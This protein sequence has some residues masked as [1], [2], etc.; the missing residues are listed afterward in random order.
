MARGRDEL[1]RRYLEALV[2]G[3]SGRANA[4]VEQARTQGWS[5]EQIYL[6]VL[7]PAQA[8][9]GARWRARRLSVAD[10][11]LAT[12]ITLEQMDRLRERIAP[13]PVPGRHAVVA[14]VEGEGHAI[15]ARML[16]DFLLIDG[17]AVDYLGANTPTADLVELVARRDPDLVAL[18][19]TQPEHLP[20]VA[21][22]AT[23]LRRLSPPPRV[24]AGG[25]ALQ[26]RPRAAATLAVDAVAADALSGMHEA[27]RVVAGAPT[28]QATGKDYFQRLGQQVQKLRS[29]KGWTQQQL[30]AAAGLDR[31]YISGLERGKQNPTVGA[32]LRLARA[33][34]VPLD[35]LVILGAEGAGNPPIVPPGSPTD[36]DVTRRHGRRPAG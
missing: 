6:H 25:A 32:L 18:S 5:V 21:A 28:S 29:S 20:A 19:V 16:A 22:A 1:H 34:E 11:H 4:I 2:G 31:T 33:L 9:I 17:W 24:I 13:K 35:R 10:E 26:G 27:R 23:A 7:A 12:E 36:A 3:D 15:G 30:A 14:C 8:E